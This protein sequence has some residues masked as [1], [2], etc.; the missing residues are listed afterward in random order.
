MCGLFGALGPIPLDTLDAVARAL[1]HRGPDAEG[2]LVRDGVVLLHRRLRVIDLSD[3]AAQPMVN[4]DGSVQVVF[5]GEIYNHRALRRELEQAGHRFRSHADTEVIVH[6]Y[7]AWGADVVHRLDGMFAFGLW[8]QARAR[9]LLARDRVG[10]KPLYWSAAGG[11]IRFASNI[12]ALHASGLPLRV[13]LA[14]LPYYLAYGFVP[15]PLT[16]Y[17][18]VLQLPPASR[19]V[20]EHGSLRPVESWW[21]PCFGERAATDP[22]AADTFGFDDA[23]EQVRRL[24]TRAVERRLEADVPL[25][26]FLSGGIDSSIVVGLMAR[27]TREPVRT[28][29]IGFSGAPGYDETHYARLA[30]TTFGTRH[31]EFV[32]DPARFAPPSPELINR[33]V[34]LHDGPFGDSSAIPTYVVSKLT[35]EHVTVAL[36]GDGGDELFC[37]YLRFLAAEAAEVIPLGLRRAAREVTQLLPGARRERSLVARAR[38]FL[39]ASALPLDERMARWNSFFT[40]PAVLLRPEVAEALGAALPAPLAWQRETFARSTAPSVLGRVL[41]H[42][43]RTYLPNDLLVKADRTSMAHGL[44]LRSP[45]LDTALVE[46][47]AALPPA[48]LRRGRVTKRI[49]RHAFADLLPPPILRRGKMGFGVPLGDWFRGQL[50]SYVTD[51]LGGGARCTEYLSAAVVRRLLDEHMQGA[52]DHGQRLWLLLTL[53]VWLRQLGPAARHDRLPHAA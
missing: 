32:I 50:R 33:L 45:F 13:N 26:A 11:A 21:Q 25:G 17:E 49:L 18:D 48:Y 27:L 28:F 40:D 5:N 43:F 24:V 30:A 42:N 12:A 22:R 38:R 20:V 29:S 46:Y 31:T 15:P 44:E 39:D 3:A 9:L 1:H 41:E 34:E 4:E 51:L 52:S 10:K 19:L 47:A 53:E 7:E 14:A 2:R 36:T 23:A 6:G 37:G 35:R 8:D 16:P